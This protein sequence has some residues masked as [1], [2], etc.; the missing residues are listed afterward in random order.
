MYRKK[1]L[2]A[3]D[4]DEIVAFLQEMIRARSDYPPGDTREVAE[5]CARKLREYEIEV[6]VVCPPQDVHSFHQD[7]VDNSTMPSVIGTL[8]SGDGPCL[9]MNAHIDTV[10]AGERCAWRHDPFAAVVEDGMVY[11]RGAGDDKGSVCAQV[12]AACAIKKAGI[13]LKGTLQINP[14]ADEEASSFRGAKWLCSSGLLRPDMVIVGEQTEN[15]VCC[16]ERSIVNLRVT[17]KG[18]ASHGAMP[19][20]GNNAT[21][22]MAEFIE[23]VHKELIPQVEAFK[24]PFLPPTTISTTKIRGGTKVNII[25]EFCD[26][27]IDCRMVPGVTEEWIITRMNELLQRLSNRGPAFEWKIETIYSEGGR[28]T[29][30]DPNE[31]LVQTLLQSAQEV[32]QT[33]QIPS[34]YQQAS[35]GRVFAS[36]G[37]PIAIYGPGDPG[38]AHALNEHVPIAQLVEATRV[39]ALTACKLLGT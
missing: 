24:H 34:G 25:P 35:D 21:V 28:A 17:I 19:W 15:I 30:T 7:G 37:V 4:E 27:E 8:G 32:T 9:L 11:G 3:I 10:Q 6:Q 20:K 5:V 36:L 31:P 22:R 1:L 38:L 16:A 12:M 23:L 13:H 39:L 18:R 29:N 26:L 2:S 33:P 14:V